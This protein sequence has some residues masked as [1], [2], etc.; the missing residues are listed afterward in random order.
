[1]PT[2]ITPGMSLAEAI[3]RRGPAVQRLALDL[4]ARM[5]Q[6]P[7]PNVIERAHSLAWSIYNAREDERFEDALPATA[8][9]T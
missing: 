3:G 4:V 6:E 5:E 1:M 2:Q 8:R 7:D 9:G